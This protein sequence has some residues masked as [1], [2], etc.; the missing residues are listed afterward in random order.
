MRWAFFLPS[1]L[2]D[3][4]LLLRTSC[5]FGLEAMSELI[6]LYKSGGM[7]GRT[8]HSATT[9]L[10]RT[11]QP[12]SQQ[13]WALLD[14]NGGVITPLQCKQGQGR[15]W[16]GGNGYYSVWSG[17]GRRGRDRPLTTVSTYLP[18]LAKPQWVRPSP[19]QI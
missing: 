12:P 15:P 11:P 3:I 2:R 4:S 19:D 6:S 18:I 1:F 16:V 17:L 10:L 9:S 13:V 7:D 14:P 5:R 8:G